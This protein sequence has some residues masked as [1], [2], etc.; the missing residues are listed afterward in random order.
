M[1]SSRRPADELANCGGQARET[2]EQRGLDELKLYRSSFGLM[3][4]AL[5]DPELSD[6]EFRQV[7]MSATQPLRSLPATK[8]KVA[9]IRLQMGEAPSRLRSLMQQVCTLQI[10]VPA[11]H[12][13]K[14]A[15]GTLS[16]K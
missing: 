13:L 8:G 2:V 4:G 16:D 5:D 9:A 7:A 15:L 3:I 6:A 11:D 12:P 14:R 1:R 10:D